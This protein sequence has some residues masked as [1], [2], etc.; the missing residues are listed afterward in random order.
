MA[1]QSG[2]VERYIEQEINDST[3]EN[4][5]IPATDWYWV[6][7]YAAIRSMLAR[8]ESPFGGRL[9]TEEIRSLRSE[10]SAA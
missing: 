9:T 8:S 5:G 6:S 1:K 10:I 4:P 7:R 3:L 2:I